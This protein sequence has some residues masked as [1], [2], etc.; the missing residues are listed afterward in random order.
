MDLYQIHVYDYSTSEDYYTFCTPE[1]RKAIDNYLDNRR[2]D[3]ERITRVSPLLRAE[4]N[5]RLEYDKN[6]LKFDAANNTAIWCI[7]TM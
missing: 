1:C 4:Y 6:I 2:R 5:K 7:D 3:G